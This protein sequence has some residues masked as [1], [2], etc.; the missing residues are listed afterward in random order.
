MSTLINYETDGNVNNPD[1][2]L[3]A[4]AALELAIN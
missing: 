1:A 4:S 3:T 2:L